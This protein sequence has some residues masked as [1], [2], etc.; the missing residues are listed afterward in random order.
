M[1]NKNINVTKI[2]W[3][4]NRLPG[5]GVQK[6]KL[7]QEQVEPIGSLLDSGVLHAL[8]ERPEWGKKFELEL[9]AALE[10][11]DFD[12]EAKACGEKGIR[13]INLTDS[14]YPKQLAQIY[15]PPLILYVRGTL[16]PE[17]EV[18]LAIV[19]TR[20]PTHYGIYAAGCFSRELAER[21]V[22]IVSG[23][24]RGIDGEAH[25]AAVKAKGRTIAVFGSGLDVVYPREHKTL[26]DDILEHGAVISEFPLGTPPLA[27]N[28]PLRN[29]IISG[30]SMGVL[31]VEANQRSGSLI[32]ASSALDEGREVYAVPGPV[33][34]VTSRGTNELI[35]KGAKIVTC[36]DN[37]LEDLM[38]QLQA[39]T[40]Q[41]RKNEVPEPS[42]T[43]EEDPILSR[44]KGQSLSFDE[45]LFVTELKAKDLNGKLIQLEL[46]GLVKREFG[47]RY[48]V[49]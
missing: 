35:G 44:F 2:V 41:W 20:H 21:G 3:T 33:N 43:A 47:G 16:V 4:L 46:D 37:I 11:G 48:S 7:L 27:H 15:D 5:F 31:V 22:T 17:D 28:F 32:T 30:L 23:M 45:L 29:R 9:K 12:R 36:A 6:F 42:Q 10:T 25:R 40:K 19:G 38:P 26:F 13:I 39:S 14:T 8:R 49:V 24:A 34:S 1:S 18:A